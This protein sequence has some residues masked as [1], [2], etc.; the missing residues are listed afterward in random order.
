M[1]L[2]PKLERS[3]QGCKK[4]CEGW[5]TGKAYGMAFSPSKPCFFLGSTGCNIYPNRPYDPCQT[6]LCEWRRDLRLPDWIKPDRSGRIFVARVVGDH[7][8]ML[9]VTT[10]RDM[11]ARIPGWAATAAAQHQINFLIYHDS[12]WN[13]YSTNTEFC[14]EVQK[15]YPSVQIASLKQ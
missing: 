8:Y 7:Q 12:Q 11:D 5:L 14:A 4:C 15:L 1:Q 2:K 9:A 3:C 13:V 10:E 6:F